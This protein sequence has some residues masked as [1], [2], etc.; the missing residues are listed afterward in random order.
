MISSVQFID[1]PSLYGEITSH[2]QESD[3]SQWNTS[4]KASTGFNVQILNK[5]C[6][7]ALYKLLL[8]MA[9]KNDYTKYEGHIVS[10]CLNCP[11]LVLSSKRN[12][13]IPN[14]ANP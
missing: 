12:F 2:D 3:E 8:K 9:W 6:D 14:W 11:K 1:Q 13:L 5:V 10:I 4:L 7:H